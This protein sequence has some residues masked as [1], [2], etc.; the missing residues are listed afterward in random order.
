MTSEQN[1]S[2]PADIRP[3]PHCGSTQIK[4]GVEINQGIDVGPFGLVF[5]G[6]ARLRGTERLRADLCLN[7]GAVTRLFVRNTQKKWACS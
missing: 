5:T 7:C 4:P 2:S 3:C 1:L 6:F